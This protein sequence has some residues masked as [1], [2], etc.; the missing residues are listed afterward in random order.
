[1]AQTRIYGSGSGGFGASAASW[2]TSGFIDWSFQCS[3]LVADVQ[4]GGDGCYVYRVNNPSNHFCTYAIPDTAIPDN[5]SVTFAEWGIRYQDTCSIPTGARPCIDTTQ[6]S[7]GWPAICSNWST[8]TSR[9][10]SLSQSGATTK[11]QTWGFVSAVSG[12][13]PIFY[14]SEFALRL[15]FTLPTPTATTN[16]ATNLNGTSATLN[17]TINPNTA[18]SVY[19]VSYKFQWG[20]TAAYGNETAIVGGQTGSSNIAASA[21]ISGLSSGTTYHFR[22]VA[23]NADV[24]TN[25]S[26]ATFVSGIFD[27][28]VLAF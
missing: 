25:G 14:V 9:N 10:T 28:T 7:A 22:V 11:G 20:A 13:G 26:D 15:T 5:A 23:F 3:S 27:N 2:T 21:K 24:T 8:D 17:G 1:M 18:T 4:D 19:P 12:S 6:V 16:A